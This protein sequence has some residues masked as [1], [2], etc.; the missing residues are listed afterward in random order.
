MHNDLWPPSDLV[1]ISVCLIPILIGLGNVAG[2]GGSSITKIPVLMLILN[3][4]QR[5]STYMSY[6]IN[7]GSGVTNVL[8][9]IFERH[10]NKD[11]PLIDYNLLLVIT[12]TVNLGNILGIYTNIFLPELGSN[13]FFTTFLFVASFFLLKKG[14]KFHK[15]EKLKKLS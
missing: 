8:L 14:K 11:R 9:L 13:L 4:S 15:E 12:P 6:C 3:Y 7:F 5:S 2:L 10:P 1:V